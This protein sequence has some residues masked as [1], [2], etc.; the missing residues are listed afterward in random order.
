M[1]Y[2]D[3][4]QQSPMTPPGLW[5]SLVLFLVV[6]HQQAI[7]LTVDTPQRKVDQGT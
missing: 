3:L 2:S 7:S 6:S 5:T 4:D 1:W